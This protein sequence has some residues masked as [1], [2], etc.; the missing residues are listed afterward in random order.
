MF[1]KIV[2][3][4]QSYSLIVWD[5]LLMLQVFEDWTLALN[6]CLQILLHVCQITTLQ[7][8]VD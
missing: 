3:D 2:F 5:G 6:P 1:P 8:N 7:R 4:A